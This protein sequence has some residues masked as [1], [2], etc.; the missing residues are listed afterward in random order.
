MIY[1]R[2]EWTR[3][4]PVFSEITAIVPLPRCKRCD[5]LRLFR[6]S[7]INTEKRMSRIPI[8]TFHSE[9]PFA[10]VSNRTSVV[11]GVRK[12]S[13]ITTKNS[14]NPEMTYES[15]G[16]L[17]VLVGLHITF[18][19]RIFRILSQQSRTKPVKVCSH[20]PF[21]LFERLSD[22]LYL[23]TPLVNNSESDKRRMQSVW[24]F[25]TEMGHYL[26]YA[27]STQYKT[28]KNDDPDKTTR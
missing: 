5:P 4:K 1:D 10:S 2:V 15:R 6:P 20:N 12:P 19:W 22:L 16:S 11:P 24:H 28:T 7:R 3:R 26:L 8:C 17:G 9:W 27:K 21:T 18:C 23:V 25:L 13:T 14:S